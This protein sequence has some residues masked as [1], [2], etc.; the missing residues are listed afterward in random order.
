VGE[1]AC[2]RVAL[3][4]RIEHADVVR[5]R[6]APR[7]YLSVVRRPRAECLIPTLNN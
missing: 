3:E 7:E 5:A 4:L 1:A 6:L 2:L